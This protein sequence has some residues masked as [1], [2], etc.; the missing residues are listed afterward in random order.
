MYVVKDMLCTKFTIKI[1]VTTTQHHKTYLQPPLKNPTYTH[2][3]LCSIKYVSTFFR[4]V[5][6]LQI[7]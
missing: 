5:L 6:T 7:E 2:H 1:L 3:M 4:I